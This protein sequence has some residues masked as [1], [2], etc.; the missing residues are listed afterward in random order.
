[1]G[2]REKLSSL[3]VMPEALL[4]MPD[5]H[6]I[7][8]ARELLVGTGRVVGKAVEGSATW[9]NGCRH[10]NSCARHRDC[11]YLGCEHRGFDIGPQIDACRAAMLADGAGDG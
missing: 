4:S 8:L 6:R 5:A 3:R 11:M 1:M 2:W 9:P 7:A 10:P